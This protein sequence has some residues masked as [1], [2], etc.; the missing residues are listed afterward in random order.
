VPWVLALLM[1]LA[2]VPC[3][4][5]LSPGQGWSEATG[6]HTLTFVL[7]NRGPTSCPL[8]GYPRVQF[9]DRRGTLPFVYH[10]GGDQMLTSKPP[11]LVR[12]APGSRAYVAVNKYRCDLGDVREPARVVLTPPGRRRALTLPVAGSFFGWCGP[13][14][15]GSL[16]SVTPVEPTE[17]ALS[18]F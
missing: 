16:V 1:L 9:R 4:L 3:R 11:R 17:R 12:L 2:T 10:H 5:T 8:V 6:Q 18:R 7:T 15:P 14:D 13:G